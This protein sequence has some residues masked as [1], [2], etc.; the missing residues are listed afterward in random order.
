MNFEK[1]RESDVTV[2]AVLYEL[3][4]IGE[5]SKNISE[6]SRAKFPGVPWKQ[7]SGMRDIVIHQYHGVMLDVIW[8][9]VTYRVAN[10]RQMLSQ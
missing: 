7:I 9:T 6:S 8:E 1:F 3:N 10:L 2:R 4:V 5:T